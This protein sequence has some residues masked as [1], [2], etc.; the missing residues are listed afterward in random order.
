MK[1]HDLMAMIGE[2]MDEIY[3]SW[4]DVQDIERMSIRDIYECGF[5]HGFE[6]G[7]EEEEK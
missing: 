6:L 3:D 2:K 7:K 5:M 1:G 4:K